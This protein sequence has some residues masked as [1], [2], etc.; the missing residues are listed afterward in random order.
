MPS[1]STIGILKHN[2]QDAML[3]NILYCCQCSTC[4]ERFFR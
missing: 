2:Q 3:Y 1:D 4:F